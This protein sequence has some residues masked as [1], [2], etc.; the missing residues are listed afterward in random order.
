MPSVM[1][2]CRL[3]CN[4]VDRLG[5]NDWVHMM[6]LMARAEIARVGFAGAVGVRLG[7]VLS[8]GVSAIIAGL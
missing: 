5:R 7:L 2:E 4:N 3:Q 6:H 8:S 1:C